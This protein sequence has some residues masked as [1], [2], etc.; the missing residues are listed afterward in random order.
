MNE[1]KT[2]LDALRNLKVQTNSLACLGC[3]WEHNCSTQGC[4]IL[5]TAYQQITLLSDQ[6]AE[7]AVARA[8]L[9]KRLALAQQRADRLMVEIKGNGD[10]CSICA[11]M[12]LTPDCDRECE[13]CR[14]ACACRGCMNNSHFEWRGDA[15]GQS[16]TNGDLFRQRTD[17]E[18]VE[19]LYQHYL[20]FSDRDGAE[21]PS[22]Q[23]C[24]LKGG[25]EGKETSVCTPELH[26]AC[27]LRWLKTE[28]V[29]G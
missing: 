24:D 23:W 3:G 15:Y 14:I 11:H 6:L 10:C 12:G 7:N 4:A 22:V 26:K 5:R 18:L 8:E 17:E 29:E 27:I 28:A 1:K 16:P 2:L 9:G 21:D 20:S 19:L 13:D 25:C